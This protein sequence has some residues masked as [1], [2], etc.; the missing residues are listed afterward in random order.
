MIY[1]PFKI[2]YKYRNAHRKFQYFYYIFLG[3]IPNNIKRIIAKFTKLTFFET[4]LELSPDE[5]E[6]LEKNYNEYWYENFFLS[7]HLKKSKKI[8][9][10]LSDKDK[11]NSAIIKKMGEEWIVKHLKSV[12]KNNLIYSYN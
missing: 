11:P 2:I 8:F 7:D 1:K 5:I 9:T 12:K 4:L 3:S 10:S 6:L